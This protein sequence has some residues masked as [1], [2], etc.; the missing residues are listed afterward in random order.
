LLDGLPLRVASWWAHPCIYSTDDS[1]DI[2]CWNDSLGKP[3]PVQIATTGNWNGK[4]IG[5]TGGEGLNYNHAKLGISMHADTPFSIFG[6]MNQ[7]GALREGYTYKKQECSSSQ[8]GRGGT[9]Y[10]VNNRELFESMTKLLKGD[11]APT[12]PPEDERYSD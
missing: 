5:L 6:D 4:E 11:S 8:N 7:Q 10:V 12:E 2:Q 9:F 1:S 3:G